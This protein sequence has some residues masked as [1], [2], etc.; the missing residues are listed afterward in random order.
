MEYSVRCASV[1]DTCRFP[2]AVTVAQHAFP[3]PLT[4]TTIFTTGASV[5]LARYL[6]DLVV[7]L[8]EYTLTLATVRPLAKM[9]VRTSMAFARKTKVIRGDRSYIRLRVL[10]SFSTI[11]AV[12]LAQRLG[13]I[14]ALVLTYEKEGRRLCKFKFSAFLERCTRA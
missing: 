9:D 5:L 11:F 10:S 4:L 1:L 12:S 2:A 14:I 6:Q 8:L 13:L 3:S 7:L